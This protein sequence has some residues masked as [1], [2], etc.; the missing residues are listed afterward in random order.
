MMN[1]KEL[2]FLYDDIPIEVENGEPEIIDKKIETIFEELEDMY[3]RFYK[4]YE[5]YF[6]TNFVIKMPFYHITDS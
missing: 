2:S 5:K 6:D 1:D 4:K 3:T